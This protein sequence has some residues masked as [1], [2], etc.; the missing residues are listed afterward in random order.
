[1]KH[2]PINTAIGYHGARGPGLL[3]ATLAGLLAA[4][5]VNTDMS[6]L[7]RYIEKVNARESSKIEPIPPPKIAEIF[8]YE[9]GDRVDPFR[10]FQVEEPEVAEPAEGAAGG[11]RPPE[12]H[13]REELEYFPLDALRMVGT[14]EKDDTMWGLVTAPDGAVHRVRTGNYMGR[15]YGKITLVAENRIELLEIVPNASGSGW[16]ERPAKLDLVE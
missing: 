15:N 11:P 2:R 7:E 6:D 3:A 8:I 9:P 16:Q 4:G 12:N 14:L 13:V 10:P 5:C 1:M